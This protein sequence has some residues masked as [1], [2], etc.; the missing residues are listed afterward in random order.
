MPPAIPGMAPWSIPAIAP[1]MPPMPGVAAAPGWAP[2]FMPAM[3][4]C[5]P[6]PV[7]SASTSSGLLN[8]KSC[9]NSV[10]SC[11]A[12]AASAALRTISGA[13]RSCISCVGTWLCIQWVPGCG[14]KS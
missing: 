5:P 7:I 6:A 4:P 2:W 14:A 9:R 11:R 12:A 1:P 10:A 13:A 3:A 8:E